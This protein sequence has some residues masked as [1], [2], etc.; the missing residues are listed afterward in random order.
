M[1][2]QL[3]LS[4]EDVQK[5]LVCL[6][7]CCL[8]PLFQLVY[9]QVVL[10][11]LE[12]CLKGDIKDPILFITAPSD[13]VDSFTGL[14]DLVRKVVRQEGWDH[15][16]VQ[17]VLLSPKLIIANIWISLNEE[18]L[19]RVIDLSS[20]HPCLN[21]GQDWCGNFFEDS[22]DKVLRAWTSIEDIRINS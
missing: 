8:N 10:F 20:N 17:L 15:D 11:S 16:I 2:L 14:K 13:E 1:P 9:V 18:L 22:T 5:L 12:R 3:V 21:H 7:M 4:E 6:L 19:E